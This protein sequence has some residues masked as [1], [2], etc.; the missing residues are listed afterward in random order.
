MNDKYLWKGAINPQEA[1]SLQKQMA[2]DVIKYG[3]ISSPSYIAGIDIAVWKNS[4]HAQAAIVVLKYPRLEIAEIKKACGEI[5]FPYIPGLLSFREIPLI[6]E[7]WQ[8]LAILPDIIM[9]DGHGLAHPRRIG[10]A[11]HLGL[12]V[13]IP[14]IGCA[15]SKLCGDFQT[16]SDKSGSYTNLL[17]DGEIIGAALRTKTS[18]K[19]LF[20][21]VGH[22]ISLENSIYWVMRCCRGYR[23]PQPTRLAHLAAGGNL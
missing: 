19:P 11:S 2:A 9:V 14:T 7:A 8:K 17:D 5:T 22:K 12:L 1:I 21:S 4:N 13:D 23:S 6:L 20:I 15:K 16:P 18:V 10:I 3:E